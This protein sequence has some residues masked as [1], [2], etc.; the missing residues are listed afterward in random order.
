MGG[1]VRLASG[2]TILNKRSCDFKMAKPIELKEAYEQAVQ[3]RDVPKV[4]RIINGFEA[5]SIPTYAA[6]ALHFMC[7][8]G[9]LD[10]IK[11]LIEKYKY[12]T[13]TQHSSYGFY[14]NNDYRYGY[15]DRN[16]SN[17]GYQGI[18]HHRYREYGYRGTLLHVVCNRDQVLH[19][20]R[21]TNRDHGTEEEVSS[22][23]EYLINEVGLSTDVI[24]EY[25]DGLPLHVACARHSLDRVKMVSVGCDVNRQDEAGNTPLHMACQNGNTHM[26]RY[27][28]E[29]R[30][31][32]F[33][34]AN[35]KGELPLHLA[36]KHRYSKTIVRLVSVGCD[37]NR[38]DEAGNTPLHMAFQNS[39]TYIVQYLVEEKKCDVN[40][41]N[42]K[43][44]LPLHLAC[45]HMYGKEIVQLVSVGCDVN[46]QDEAGNT[47]LQMAFQ[48]GRT[49]I[50]Q[51]LVEEKKCGFNVAN[52]KGELPLHL[53]CKHRYSKTIVRLVS[54][55]CDVN[56]QDEAGNTPLHMACQNGST[57]IVQYLVE[58][59]KC[60]FNVANNKGELPLH[61]ACKH[62]YGKEI[63]LLV[64]VGRDVNRQDEAGNTPLHMAC[65][66][67][68]ADI[69]RYLVEERKCDFNVAN[70]KG[71]L[72]L[73]LACKH[74]YGKEIVQLV[75]V[76]C[77]VNRQDEAGNTPL[78]MAFQNGRTDIVQYLVEEKKCGFNV[79]NNKGELPLHLACKHRYS[80]TIV[81]LVSVGCDVNRQDEAGN[82]PL[83]M[84]CQNGS[85]DIVQYLVE[86]RKCDFN[87]ANNKG[88]LPLHLACKHMYGK[89]IVLLVSVGRDVNRQDEAGNTPLQ[90]AFQ[91][92]RTD[93]VQYLV[94]EKKCGFNVANNKGELPLH[95]ACKHR[96]SKTI[97]RLVSV[98]CDVN[99][100]DEAGNTPLHMACQ[101][102]STDMVRY[103]VEE[104]K[105]G[106][107]VANNKGELPLHLACMRMY[108]KE[109]VQLVSVGCDVN[110]QDEAG[111]TPLHIACRNSDT[112]IVKFLVEE[113]KCVVDHVALNIC[114]IEADTSRSS[115]YASMSLRTSKHTIESKQCGLT[116][117]NAV[118]SESNMRS[119]FEEAFRNKD[120]DACLCLMMVG[121]CDVY[122]Q[123]DGIDK[124]DVVYTLL[125]KFTS[126]HGIAC[127][128]PTSLIEGDTIL[129][130]ASYNH[131]SALIKHLIQELDFSPN[132]VNSKQ[133]YPL[134]IA[135]RSGCSLEVIKLLASCDVNFQ[136]RDGNAPLHLACLRHDTNTA[137]FLVKERHCSNT[138]VNNKGE[139]PLHLACNSNFCIDEI[140][141]VSVDCDVNRQDNAGNTPLHL[142]CSSRKSDIVKFLIQEKRC[143]T[144]VVNN[145]GELPLHLACRYRIG[146]S[147]VKLMS[148]G[149][150]PNVTTKEGNTILH[151][152]CLSS[153]ED[154]EI[155]KFLCDEFGC[156]PNLS[157]LRGARPLHFAC[158]RGC[159]RVVEYLVPKVDVDALD[160]VNRTPLMCTPLDH[161]NIIKTLV[162]HGANPQYLYTTYKHFFHSYSS[163]KPPP[164]PLNIIV[165]GNH[166]T[167]KST[168]IE[169]LKS[170]GCQDMVVAEKLTAGIISLAYESESFGSVIWYDLAGHSEYYASH[171]AI[172][173]T[174]LSASPPLILLLV[175]IRK[176][177]KYIQQDILYW[178][179]FLHCQFGTESGTRPHLVIVLS[180]A[181][182]P[183]IC[184]SEE[185]TRSIRENLEPNFIKFQSKP[186][187][188]VAL[189][190]RIPN[191]D[192]IVSLRSQLSASF[193]QLCGIAKMNFILH[194]FYAFLLHNFK[195]LTAIT[196]S[197][198]L[199][200]TSHWISSGIDPRYFNED[201]EEANSE[202]IDSDDDS[203]PEF[204]E[205]E[206]PARLLPAKH[207]DILIL[208]KELH[209]KGHIILLKNKSEV[210]K[211]WSIMQKEV[212]LNKVNGS[213]FAPQHFR[214]H[215]KELS[216][217]TGVVTLSGLVKHF[218]H[219]DP[220]MLIGFLTHMEFCQEI[221][222]EVILQ[223]LTESDLKS[224]DPQR[225]FFFPGLVSIEKPEQ[226][227]KDNGDYSNKCGWIV[228]ATQANE[229][230]TPRFLQVL[231]LRIA[232]N[233]PLS[234]V[235]RRIIGFDPPTI[236]R[237]CSVWKNGISWK[238]GSGLECLVEVTE[239]CQAVVLML[240]SIS[241]SHDLTSHYFAH[242]SSL[243][244]V[245]TSAVS[246][247]CP[248]LEVS[249]SFCHPDHIQY[250]PR[251]CE[252]T[253][254]YSLPS[255]AHTICKQLQLVLCDNSEHDSIKLEKLVTFEPF[256]HFNIHQLFN[257]PE[258]ENVITDDYLRHIS[259]SIFSNEAGR[260]VY[261][262]FTQ[263]Q[264]DL[265]LS[266]DAI[267]EVLVDWRDSKR[268]T[269]SDL[270]CHLSQ[271]SIFCDRDP[272]VRME[273]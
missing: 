242:R 139:L 99:R 10:D 141:L 113:R 51:Y 97:V 76:G 219:H 268:A 29:E 212:L 157:N 173:H 240:R 191:S 223:L 188:I 239:Q 109:I 189:D 19:T 146:L 27:L 100:Q 162:E 30:K 272:Q 266:A 165:I 70:N 130:V 256:S 269:Y 98:G 17:F 144:D 195:S 126:E 177:L 88:E 62:M 129:H 187:S 253:A 8:Y 92:G 43:G 47:P 237:C 80:K 172:L 63:V 243:I 66:N 182:Q 95:L 232:F 208:C 179:N 110:I 2:I 265:K 229:F 115:L 153:S 152:F 133:E 263:K 145:A 18:L 241:S 14:G 198:V 161:P 83:H 236:Q 118:T 7:Y 56:R 226:I 85:T 169:A 103:L 151:Q 185:K 260:T 120:Y 209:N 122:T 94:E 181:D 78:Q 107:N 90:M 23:L 61:L 166:Q 9:S 143:S 178:L 58:D 114:G 79:A 194:C 159:D 255:I 180:F 164:T 32:D 73:H 117:L 52:N 123:I 202:S 214:Q 16:R 206:S 216:T 57:D 72:P 233:F 175:D 12:P 108:G 184:E 54:V 127:T 11:T 59:R 228:E 28:V 116:L 251:S 89:E 82:T 4:L 213:L 68:S 36:C 93:I 150:S 215:F 77:D 231:Q 105:C 176:D 261:M 106:F 271:F 102:G 168:L 140:K 267:F 155:L 137:R 183:P 247:I 96:Y 234:V 44:E 217:N 39:R 204:N 124:C 49:D 207:E 33:N 171:E 42:N 71:E 210:E 74:V 40:V 64:S 158:F 264:A 37:V 86:D 55:G 119:F 227:W 81:R 84:A 13:D 45:K 101:N 174:I 111:N 244:K 41:A 60:D 196:I 38:Q 148:N 257:S 211:S 125:C 31:C 218:P 270:H 147:E 193:K 142:A 262:M 67:C 252:D 197:D 34:V 205:E 186:V 87:V 200:L 224:K 65:Q 112:G 132:I 249:E 222:D 35:N 134:H 20:H 135:C 230:F 25:G 21:E 131:Q 24:S 128:R 154:L 273:C 5:G 46:R 6:G 160:N 245:I 221:N 199:T 48:N 1:Q 259:K 190:C 138:I 26:V 3:A 250:P 50:V 163:E 149:C 53:A 254:L 121:Q 136:D 220:D 22:I 235:N 258:K 69:V 75:S 15:L 104:K 201:E 246:D 170:E 248:S 225:Y 192:K 203:I 238:T 156:D 91:N 167:G